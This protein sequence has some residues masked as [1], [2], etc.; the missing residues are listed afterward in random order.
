MG[1]KVTIEL[2]SEALAAAR[3]AGNDLAELLTHAL[4]RRLPILHAAERAE[5]AC[6]WRQ[7]NKEAVDSINRMIDKSGGPR[8]F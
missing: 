3:E 2:D 4:R 8:T 7:E 1:E 6:R 5:A